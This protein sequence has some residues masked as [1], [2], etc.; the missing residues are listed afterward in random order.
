MADDGLILD[1]PNE[2]LFEI[3]QLLKL[4]GIHQKEF[5]E[6]MGVSYFVFSRFFSH[7]SYKTYAGEQKKYKLPHIRRAI[8]D[9]LNIPFDD[10]WGTNGKELVRKLIA[11][12]VLKTRVK[13]HDKTRRRWSIKAF[14]SNLIKLG[15]V[16]SNEKKRT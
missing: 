13:E 2:P 1:N 14:F 12:E 7:G 3:R 5:A 10:L 9:G 15:Y 16:P 4:R 8:A 6:K 11:E